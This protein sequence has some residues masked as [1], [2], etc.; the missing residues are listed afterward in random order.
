MRNSPLTYVGNVTTPTLIIHGQL[1]IRG[2]EAQAE[3]FFGGLYEQGK[4]AQ[5]VRYG[6]ESHSLAQSPANV[7]DILERSIAWF[8]RFV[9]H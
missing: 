1:D 8:D 5:Y 9:K 4:T 7:R 3:Q 6:G 2:N